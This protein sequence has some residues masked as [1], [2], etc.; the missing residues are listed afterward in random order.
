MANLLEVARVVAGTQQRMVAI[1]GLLLARYKRQQLRP[2]DIGYYDILRNKLYMLEMEGFGT[3]SQHLQDILRLV[4]LPDEAK[5]IPMPR[6]FPAFPLPPND[7]IY[8]KNPPPANQNA[9]LSGFGGLGNPGAGAVL[10]AEAGFSWTTAMVGLCLTLVVVAAVVAAIY[11]TGQYFSD[12]VATEQWAGQFQN[13]LLEQHSVGMNCLQ[14]GFTP[15]RCAA[16]LAATK[17]PP[18]PKGLGEEKKDPTPLY[19]AAGVCF[20]GAGLLVWGVLR[21]G[22]V[23]GGGGGG[24]GGT[25]TIIIP[26]G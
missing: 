13:Y 24:G 2:I 6:M 18:P 1:Q 16:L 10:V 8:V 15:E 26:G 3:W 23:S 21:P 25:R 9:T 12:S 17:P 11:V 22:G 5:N 7:P 14:R 4:G 20:V 19:I